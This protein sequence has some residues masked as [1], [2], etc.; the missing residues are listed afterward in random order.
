MG[1]M[2]STE[3]DKNPSPPV[4]E[5]NAGA[6]DIPARVWQLGQE[7]DTEEEPTG[8]PD[9]STSWEHNL[10]LRAADTSK[11][12]PGGRAACWVRAHREQE[13]A[14]L[15]ARSPC[16][17]LKS[18]IFPWPLKSAASRPFVGH[19]LPWRLVPR[20]CASAWWGGAV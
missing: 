3:N 20:H 10:S 16:A 6:V 11:S 4:S 8:C 15:R 13:C 14:S 17:P 5:S 2:T 1:G 19:E 9:A 7:Q 12:P 18:R